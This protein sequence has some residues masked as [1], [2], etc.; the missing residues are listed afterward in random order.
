VRY[1]GEEFV[2]VIAD[3]SATDALRIAESVRATFEAITIEAPSGAIR[4]TVSGGVVQLG[5]ELL[6]AAGIALAD[7]WLSQAKRAGRNQIVGG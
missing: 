1:G 6:V 7:V 4:V 2:A 3:A 5:E